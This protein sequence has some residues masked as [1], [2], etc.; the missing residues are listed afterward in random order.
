MVFKNPICSLPEVGG[1]W[2]GGE[3]SVSTVTWHWKESTVVRT[4]L[5]AQPRSLELPWS[6][7]GGG[8]PG[9]LRVSGPGREGKEHLTAGPGAPRPWHQTSVGQP[10]SAT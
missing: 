4:W 10:L 8:E 7:M 1:G 6:C 9:A 3:G 5:L 2:G